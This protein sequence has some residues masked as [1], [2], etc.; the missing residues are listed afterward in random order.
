MPPT[1]I[2][3]PQ[4][5][6]DDGRLH[7]NGGG[8]SAES[9]SHNRLGRTSRHGRVTSPRALDFDEGRPAA[10]ERV[11]ARPAGCDLGAAAHRHR[12]QG[13]KTTRTHWSV[14]SVNIL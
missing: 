9:S 12:R 5:I 10:A 7:H 6:Y 8:P 14:L 13:V 2:R 3:R 1:F 11:R 4:W